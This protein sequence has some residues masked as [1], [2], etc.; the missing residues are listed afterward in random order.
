[1]R[2]FNIIPIQQIEDF[3][4]LYKY[5]YYPGNNIEGLP[6]ISQHLRLFSTFQEKTRLINEF[7]VVTLYFAGLRHT[8]KLHVV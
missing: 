7:E 3:F 1:M 6:F 8:M 2:T 4:I 5:G